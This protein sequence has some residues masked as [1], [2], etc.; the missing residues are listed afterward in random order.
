MTVEELV[1]QLKTYSE[2]EL[3]TELIKARKLEMRTSDVQNLAAKFDEMAE[4]ELGMSAKKLMSEAR[5][6]TRKPRRARLGKTEEN[7]E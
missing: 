4:R 2:L 6:G 1:S 7:S 3:A 5:K